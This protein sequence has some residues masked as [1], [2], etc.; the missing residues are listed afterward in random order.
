MAEGQFTPTVNAADLLLADEE[1]MVEYL[2]RTRDAGGRCNFSGLVGVRNLTKSQRHELGRRLRAADSRPKKSSSIN[3]DE[4]LARLICVSNEQNGS[5]SPER[6]YLRSPAQSSDSTDIIPLGDAQAACYHEL[7]EIGGRP[8]CSIQHLSD[9]CA[10]PRASYKAVLPWLSDYPDSEDVINEIDSLFPRQLRRWLEF[11]KWQWDNRGIKESEEGFSFFFKASRSRWA[12][13][14]AHDMVSDPD[15]EGTIR[16]QWQDLPA[17]RQLPD[18]QGFSAYGE[19]VKRR[20]MPY[21]FTRSLQ[22]KK[23]PLRQTTWTNWLEYINYEQW[24]SEQRTTAAE[25]LMEEQY[26]QPRKRLLEA[27][28]RPARKT[29]RTHRTSAVNISAASGP[30]QIRQR[31]LDPKTLAKELEAVE[32]DLDVTNRAVAD[33]IRDTTQYERAG[34]AAYFQ[35]LRVKWAVEEA[36]LME[37]EMSHQRRTAK[38]NTTVGPNENKKRRRGDDIGIPPEPRPK[39]TK[40]GGGDKSALSEPT[41]GK[42]QLRRSGRSTRSECKTQGSM[43]K[44]RPSS[45]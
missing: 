42:P 37:T 26:H 7:I 45:L 39:S 27:S 30:T 18:D 1:I 28:E 35:K 16:L 6:G 9:L 32:D 25:S 14:G 15:F 38:S 11:H 34:T 19:A 22:L 12:R 29:R 5:Q 8:V 17:Y 33:Y 2:D 44:I 20:L 43:T 3:V 36:R 4:I 24:W 41:P 23:N 13:M 40:R 31:H 10:S 21:H